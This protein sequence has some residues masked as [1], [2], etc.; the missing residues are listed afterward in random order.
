MSE[1]NLPWS[2]DSTTGHIRDNAGNTV[3]ESVNPF[4][5]KKIVVAMNTK[6]LCDEIIAYDKMSRDVANKLVE[7]AEEMKAGT[8]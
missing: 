7:L 2:Y 3:I 1:L 4:Y 5:G 6:A 8:I